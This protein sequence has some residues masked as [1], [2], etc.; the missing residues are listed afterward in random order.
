MCGI[1]GI[2][3][4]DEHVRNMHTAL[5]QCGFFFELQ[6]QFSAARTELKTDFTVGFRNSITPCDRQ[7]SEIRN[8]IRA[9]IRSKSASKA[10]LVQP[11]P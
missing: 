3:V 4:N 7:N 11:L 8:E 5:S 10:H 9:K 6:K 1:G 2:A